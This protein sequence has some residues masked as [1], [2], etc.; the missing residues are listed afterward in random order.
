MHAF[1]VYSWPALPFIVPVVSLLRFIVMDRIRKD[2]PGFVAVTATASSSS[3]I[4]MKPA[5]P[6]LK[7]R[8]P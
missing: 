5:S 3:L 4:L 8:S 7:S 6:G 2:M 1:E